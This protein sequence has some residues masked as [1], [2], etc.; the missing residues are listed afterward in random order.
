MMF[1]TH[2]ALSQRVQAVL[3]L[4]LGMI[5]PIFLR[6]SALAGQVVGNTVISVYSR[7]AAGSHAIRTAKRRSC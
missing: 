1:E 7:S 4:S 2:G 3:Q 6:I 5:T